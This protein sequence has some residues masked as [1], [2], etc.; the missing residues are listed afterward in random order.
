MLARR[1]PRRHWLERQLFDFDAVF[2][3][4][5]RLPGAQMRG[6]ACMAAAGH[7]NWGARRRI[8]L[9][10]PGPG[11]SMRLGPFFV[12]FCI[13]V[14]AASAGA[15]VY[16]GLGFAL[17]D[18]IIVAVA[19]L[20]ALALYNTVSSR[21]NV[22][23]VVGSQLADLSRG[24]ADLARQVAEIG[25]RLATVE[26]KLERTMARGEGSSEPLAGEISE[27]GTLVNQL[28]ET[29]A[30]HEALF[31]EIEQAQ[32]MHLLL[33]KQP[34]PMEPPA[35]AR[36]SI[37]AVRPEAPPAEISAPA[38][39]PAAA[40]ELSPPP[41]AA[42]AVVAPAPPTAPAPEAAQTP[43]EASADLEMLA[44]IRAAIEASR[45]DLHLQPIVTLPQ[46]KV[47]Y[48]EAMSRL[49]TEAG[50]VLLAGQ[51]IAQAEAAGLV[52]KIDN[53]VVFR[54]V[55]VLRRLLLKNREVGVFCNLSTAT[56][57]DSAI[58]PQLLEFLD[59]NRAIAP[60]LVI[61][62][63]QAGLRGLGPIENESLAA[64]NERGFHFSMDNV[65]DLRLEP[66]ELASRGFR[67]VK[68]PASLLLNRGGAAA[69]I[70]PAD[71]P[72]LLGRFG[73]DLIA[74]KIESEGSVVDL[75]D[76]DVKF[77]QGFLFSPPRPVRAEALQGIAD[78][79]D[80]VSREATAAAPEARAS[81][82]EPGKRPGALAQL[83]RRV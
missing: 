68:L 64:L 35:P 67:F 54:C 40:A 1:S 22:R 48:Y 24:T 63:A 50:T 61:E 38:E 8:T 16:F 43:P 2:R 33:H 20:T 39:A 59:A 70:H 19:V 71:F 14:I 83:A 60:S 52:P 42:P 66:R 23:A 73:I 10:P 29:V 7:R 77:G 34:T 9:A 72:N 47:R 69:D 57:T 25:R 32:Q 58:F 62:F 45:I 26:S 3:D 6:I 17:T 28:A 79:N 13:V 53:L 12:A 56:L 27:L 65:T 81:P 37:E 76:C 18:A 21:L 46:R 15:V 74:E 5:A 36:A 80:V 30:L 41:A 75:L 4:L 55:Q 44:T 78:R 11:I 82:T 49:R 51:F 31:N